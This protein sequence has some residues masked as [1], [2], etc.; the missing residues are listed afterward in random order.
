MYLCNGEIDE[1][2]DYEY[3]EFLMYCIIANKIFNLS[4]SVATVERRY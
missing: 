3:Q 2:G 1:T 4:F